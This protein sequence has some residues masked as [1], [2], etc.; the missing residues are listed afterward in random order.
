M[1]GPDG[2]WQGWGLGDIDPKVTEFRQFMARKFA[3]YAGDLGDSPVYDQ[4]LADAVVQMQSRYGLPATGVINWATQVKMGFIKPAAVDDERP[5]VFSV[6]GHLS[7][8]WRGPV[9][10]TATILENEGHCWHQPIGYS[11]GA[12]PF[13]NASG[14]NELARL[15]GQPTLDNGRPFPIGTKY[16]LAGFSQGAIVVTDF[17]ANFLQPYQVHAP[18]AADC[19][20]VLMYGNPCRS[21][22]SVAPWSRMQAGP[23]QNAGLD[24]YARLD[25]LGITLPYPLMDVYRKGDIFADNE[26]DGAG[27]VKA[28]VYQAVARGDLFSDPYSLTAEIADLFSTPFQEVWDILMAIVSGIGFLATGDH[29]PH[30]SPFD[31]TGGINWARDLLTARVAA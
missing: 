24:P 22:G 9:A 4:G 2:K 20:G 8:M 18:R 25:L 17:I 26:P 10:D 19:L 14:T 11:N 13:D 31:I 28:A 15:F 7:D 23:I 12:I 21:K 5:I 6:E 16:V 1:N 30:Y 27:D 3:S 29:S